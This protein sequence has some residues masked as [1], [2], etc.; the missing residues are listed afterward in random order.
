MNNIALELHNAI[1]R[2]LREYKNVYEHVKSKNDWKNPF[3]ELISKDIPDLLK[4]GANISSPYQVVGS[5]GK[6]RWTAVTWIAV[7]DSRITTSAQKGVYIVYLLN[8]DTQ[9]LYLTFEIAAT[10]AM[11]VCQNPDGPTAFI[12]VVGNSNPELSS[13]LQKKADEIRKAIPD[14]YF[15]KDT[16]INSGA[17][18][19]DSGAI[20]YK[21]YSLQ[22]LPAGEQLVYDLNR[23]M[24]I[25][26]RYYEWSIVPKEEWWPSLAEYDP[27][28]SKEMWISLLKNT[29]VFTP[30]RLTMMA[31]F[32]AAG[33]QAS[34][35]QLAETYGQTSDFYRMAC[36]VHLAERVHKETGCPL[37]NQENAK[38][39]PVLFVGRDTT[40]GE[41]GNYI[42]KLRGELYAALTEFNILQYLSESHQMG[43]FDSW[44]IIDESTAIKHC[45]KSFFDYRGSGVPKG[46]CWFFDAEEMSLGE[47]KTVKLIYNGVQY[48][49]SVKNESTDRRRVRIFWST[50]LG[51]LFNAFNVP[52]AA[53]TF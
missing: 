47:T 23:M 19:Y 34:C 44:E 46:I 14:D 18:G 12:G 32:Y 45:D 37:C 38:F 26:K 11:N 5:Y 40:S 15:S 41:R 28:I 33:G 6:G 39:W 2:L 25:Y 27:G 43:T 50:E 51:N 52:E 53:A 30:A 22:D 4:R 8:K 7:F 16:L 13:K 42:W 10:E 3:R 35:I 21:K 9:E 20:Y 31:Q 17:V 1:H 29:K 36:G 24:D 49:G 48:Q